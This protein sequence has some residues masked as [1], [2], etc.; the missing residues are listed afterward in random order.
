MDANRDKRSPAGRG[1]SATLCA[2]VQ[3]VAAACCRAAEPAGPRQALPCLPVKIGTREGAIFRG[4]T[5]CCFRPC[6]LGVLA[7]G[8]RRYVSTRRSGRVACSSQAH[9][10]V[11]LLVRAPDALFV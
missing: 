3:R 6:H 9:G 8:G 11:L 2:G 4:F 1:A 10:K 7:G 5:R